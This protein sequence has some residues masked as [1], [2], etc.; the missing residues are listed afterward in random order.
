MAGITPGSAEERDLSWL[1]WSNA[2]DVTPDGQ[3]LLFDEQGDG[4]GPAYSLYVRKTDGSPAVRVAD[5]DSISISDD[6]KWVLATTYAEGGSLALVPTGAGEPRIINTGNLHDVF[7]RFL[8]D[9]KHILVFAADKRVY[10]QTLDDGN[11][12]LV[13][14]AGVDANFG[15]TTADGK[16]LLG[17]D[18]SGKWAL[19]PIAGGTPVPLPKWTAGDVPINHTTDNHSFFVQNGDIPLNIYRFDF[20][21]STRQFVRQVRPA[22]PTGSE[23]LTQVFMTPD[24]KYYVYTGVRRLSTLF[25][26]SGLK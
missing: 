9:G 25:L 20:V 5:G 14:P 16:Y 12:R 1:D 10:V 18:E 17:Q 23:R 22:D 3:W 6:G 8:P 11:P 13:L 26:V 21:S 19:Y 4:G 7:G 24:G 15:I 2:R